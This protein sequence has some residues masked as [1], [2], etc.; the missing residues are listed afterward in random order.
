VKLIRPSEISSRILSLLDESDE[1]VIIVSPYMKISKW[2]KFVNKVNELKTRSILTEIYVRDDP[3]NTATYRDLDQLALPYKKIPHLHSKLYLNE[4]YGIVTSMNLLLSSEI[5]SLE[6][7]YATET[8]TEYNDL[9]GYYHRYIHIGEPVHCDTIA[10]QP[11]ADL[12]EIMRSI[13][14][15]LEKTA[16]NSWPWLAGNTLHISTGRN[17]Y[18]VSIKDGYLRIT[19]RL[20]MATGS[21][22]KSIQHPSLIVKKVG[23]LTAMKAELLPDPLPDILQLSGQA[24]HT[25]KS[26]CFTGILKA[27]APYIMESVR[28]FIDAADDLVVQKTVNSSLN[29]Y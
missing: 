2:Y 6:I 23:D 22:Q 14:E 3:D 12:K 7:G 21:R 29:T 5:N 18:R 25:L 8:W 24:Q 28:R 1:R 20:R 16:K 4:R 15:E 11:A 9:L 27:E 19:T 13:R 17:N 10:G 26:T